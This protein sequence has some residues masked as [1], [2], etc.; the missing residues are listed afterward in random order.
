[1][2]LKILNE[3][4]GS[5]SIAPTAVAVPFGKSSRGMGLKSQIITHRKNNKKKKRY[6]PEFRSSIY[7]HEIDFPNNTQPNPAEGP[8][9]IPVPIKV[10]PRYKYKRKKKI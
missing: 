4:T 10:I 1:M 7:K 8:D 6:I 9:G 5:G 3:L 2:R